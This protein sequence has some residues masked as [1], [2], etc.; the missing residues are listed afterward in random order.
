MT[1]SNYA[2]D[3]EKSGADVEGVFF[4]WMLMCIKVIADLIELFKEL[5]DEIDGTC[6]LQKDYYI[7]MLEKIKKRL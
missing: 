5:V 1:D 3:L 7:Q 4:I 2:L 6:G